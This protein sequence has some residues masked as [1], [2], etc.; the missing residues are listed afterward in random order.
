MLD[1]IR[2]AVPGVLLLGNSV[3]LQPGGGILADWTQI[4]PHANIYTEAMDRLEQSPM[5]T[6]AASMVN[7]LRDVS[8][9]SDSMASEGGF[10][11]G[12]GSSDATTFEFGLAVFLLT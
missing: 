8:T 10:V 6:T 12:H 9:A 2:T 5:Y 4:W 1:Q 7:Y 3:Y 11:I